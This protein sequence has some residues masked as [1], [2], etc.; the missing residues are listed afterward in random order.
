MKVHSVQAPNEFHLQHRSTADCPGSRQSPTNSQPAITAP[1]RSSTDGAGNDSVL[2]ELGRQF[3]EIAAELHV[4]Q[5]APSDDCEQIDALLRRLDPIE[6]AIIAA[7]A[8]SIAGL[9]VKALHVA[10]VVSE[11]WEA[12]IDQINWDAKAVRLFIESVCDLVRTSKPY[13]TK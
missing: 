6:R 8:L 13:E 2:I 12:P 9:G 4:L 11:Y 10:Y 3:E 5:K 1:T 7:P